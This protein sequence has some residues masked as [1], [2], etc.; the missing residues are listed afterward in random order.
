MASE[1]LGTLERGAATAAGAAASASSAA[2]P[3]AAAAAVMSLARMVLDARLPSAAGVNGDFAE[4]GE[5]T[6]PPPAM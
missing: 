6:V 1:S 4:E 3:A 2:A 5:G